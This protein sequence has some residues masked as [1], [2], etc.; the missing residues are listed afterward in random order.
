MLGGDG[1]HGCTGS[2]PATRRRAGRC[3]CTAAPAP[4]RS[5]DHRRFFDPG[6]TGRDLRPARRRPLQ[7]A[8]RA[9]R[10]HHADLVDDIERL[11][12]T[13]GSSA[14]WYSAAPGARR[15]RWPMR[16]RIRSA[17]AALVLRGIFLGRKREIGWFFD[18][19]GHGLPEAGAASRVHAGGRAR[20]SAGGLLRRLTDPDPAVHMP[21]ARVWCATRAACCTL[22]PSPETVQA[23]AQ[24]K[25][26]LGLA[27]MEAHYFANRL[28]LPRTSCSRI[29]IASVTSRRS[30]CRGATTWCARSPRRTSCAGLAGGEV[31]LV[32]DAGHSAMEPGI[33]AALI[34]A[35]EEM[36]VLRR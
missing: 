33:R 15:W 24:D 4:A 28:F 34:A 5:A 16:R 8:G 20:R 23:F 21:A 1:L 2:S 9:A 14:G 7:A 31:H 27:R 26:A 17:C 36:K 6:T 3:S 19:V 11:R 30:S 29:C 18:G 13:S 32:P 12:R 10:Q 25:L 35:M 22:L